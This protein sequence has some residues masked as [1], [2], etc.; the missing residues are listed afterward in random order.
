MKCY[1]FIIEFLGKAVSVNVAIAMGYWWSFCFEM[2]MK[3][4]H[5]NSGCLNLKWITLILRKQGTNRAKSWLTSKLPDIG[6]ACK[7]L[8]SHFLVFMCCNRIIVPLL[9]V[10][11]CLA[12]VPGWGLTICTRKPHFNLKVKS[13]P[14]NWLL[15]SLPAQINSF[16]KENK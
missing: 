13:Y 14:P 16:Y 10:S 11:P 1:F 2:K 15:T 6:D 12:D 9:M 5:Q 3:W 4:M 7:W 8:C